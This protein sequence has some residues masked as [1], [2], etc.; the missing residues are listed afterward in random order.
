MSLFLCS[1]YT[2]EFPAVLLN[3]STG[4]IESE[5]HSYVQPQ[6]HPILSKFCTELTGI[7]QVSM[8]SLKY[9][10]TKTVVLSNFVCLY[11]F[12]LYLIS[13]SYLCF[14]DAGRG[15]DPPPDL[16]FSVQPLVAKPAAWDGSGLSQQTTEM[17]WTFTVSKAVYFPHMVR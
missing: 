15:R 17:F 13:S 14:I 16:Y 7:T 5:F 12:T 11:S 3:T 6:E 4:E 1:L 10:A 2:V 9:T 8:H